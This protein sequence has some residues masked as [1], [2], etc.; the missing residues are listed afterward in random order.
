M[1]SITC[2]SEQIARYWHLQC[3]HIVQATIMNLEHDSVHIFSAV[4]FFSPLLFQ[5]LGPNFAG[6]TG[7]LLASLIVGAV[8][9]LPQH[10]ISH[11]GSAL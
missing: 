4:V 2:S 1:H 6:Q 5:G 8:Q 10:S 9:V 3:I 11:L 7:A